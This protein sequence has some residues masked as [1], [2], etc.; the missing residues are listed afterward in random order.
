MTEDVHR[1]CLATPKNDGFSS[2]QGNVTCRGPAPPARP[3][4]LH[5]D[6]GGYSPAK[7]ANSAGFRRLWPWGC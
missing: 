5:R 4:R 6:D 7:T 2:W 3:C 1:A